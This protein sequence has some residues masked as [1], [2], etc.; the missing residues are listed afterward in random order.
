MTDIENQIEEL[1]RQL[2]ELRSRQLQMNTEMVLMEKQLA[3]LR[4]AVLPGSQQQTVI[5]NALH[6]SAPTAE[7]ELPFIQKLPKNIQREA[8]QRR[9]RS[10]IINRE[11]EDFIGTNVI[12][13][14]GILV[15]IIGVFIGAKY[16]I[17]NELISPFMRIL[18]GYFA[19]AALVFVA[20]R[21]KKKYEYFSS[22]LVGGGLAVAYFITYIAFSFYDLMSMWL[23]FVLMVITTSAAV[24][25]A[26]W[27]NQKVIALIGQV[28]AYAIPFLLGNKSG[29]V[30]GLFAYISFINAGLLVLSFKKDW[31]ALYY[32]AFFLTWSIYL[33]WLVAGTQVTKHFSAGLLFLTINFFTFYITFLS[34][35]IY[36]KEQYRLGEI[37]ILLLNALFYFFLGIYLINESFQNI[38]F[39]TW[40]TIANAVVH[41]VAGYFVYRLKLAD[42][43]VFQFVYG[44]GL[45][46]VTVAIP[47]GLDGSWVTLLWSVEATALFYIAAANGRAVYADIALPLVIIAVSS[48]LQD[49]SDSYF[50]SQSSH[51]IAGFHTMPFANINFWLSLFVCACLGYISY[52][53][54]KKTFTGINSF[55]GNFF[56]KMV[57]VIFLLLLY[58]VLFNEIHFAWDEII[59]AN[60]VKGK[61]VINPVFPLFQSLTLLIFSC[62]Y[63]AFWLFAIVRFIKKAKVSYFL[64]VL[65]AIVDIVFLTRGL[66]L[67]GEL[68]EIYLSGQS[69]IA[70]SSILFYRYISF[71][72]LAILW[73]SARKSFKAFNPSYS[74]QVAFSSLFNLTHLTVISNEFINWMDL[75]GYQN[76]YKLGL[77]LIGGAYALALIFAGIIKN[78]K[79]LRIS[80][81]ILFGITLFKL[82]FYDL[83]SLSTISKTVVLV[84][85]GILL[86]F[87]SFLYNKYK[88]LL[89]GKEESQQ[90]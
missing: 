23:A 17:D 51:T 50:Y 35:K 42:N 71:A 90:K 44:L 38:H 49:W 43:T 48:L 33:F 6:A 67:T 36:K 40:F 10:L 78:K 80:A 1:A 79:Y 87:A 73:I 89:A 14:I 56:N 39:L 28:A 30:F 7:T 84:L 64:L 66:Y 25:I 83:A 82:F 21:L 46:F 24:G 70:V 31:K 22:V 53:A 86:L 76:Q 26:L 75:A 58:F 19:A 61:T 60:P 57:P 37:G 41:F 77:S 11:T 62:M 81:M 34:Y 45:L 47:I 8:A 15:T 55:T 9:K 65:S 68:R 88:D 32:I 2:A 54:Q 69:S 85:S 16:A 29:N 63:F 52:A 5:K 74:L 59:S 3:S 13:K 20:L 18:A 4:A 12:S 72:A 27:Y